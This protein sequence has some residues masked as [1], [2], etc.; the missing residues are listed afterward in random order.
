MV[1]TDSIRTVVG[2]I[3]NVISFFLFASPGPTIFKIWKQKA[4]EG[5]EPDPYL[6]CILNCL[7]WIFYGLPFVRPH[8][9]LIVTINGV[10]LVMEVF[11]ILIFVLYG[12]SKKRKKIAL[13]LIIELIFF[14]VIVLV[15]LLCFKTT[16][17]R[18]FFVGFICVFFNCCMYL[19]PLLIMKKV[20]TT[21]SVKYMPFLL[22]LANFLNGI[23]WVTFALLRFDPFVLT[24]NGI[25]TLGAIA[26]LILY[27]C[28]YGSTP[29][30]GEEET[31]KASEVELS[32]N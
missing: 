12:N 11:Y 23:T 10:G 28:Y 15:T 7:M 5:F 30:D 17:K 22:S 8:S 14:A 31:G 19:S 16:D 9:I 4:V 26:Q 3:G 29:K 2:V 1:D 25:G 13:V 6:A 20:I 27:A 24:G 21:K 18:S 32:K